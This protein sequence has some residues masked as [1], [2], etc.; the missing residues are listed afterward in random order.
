M[1]DRG[2]FYSKLVIPAQAGIQKHFLSGSP[3]ARGQWLAAR[4][5]GNDGK[6]SPT[7]QLNKRAEN[8]QDLC[9]NGYFAI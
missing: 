1:R 2:V 9:E 3:L 6:N 5:R 7:G 8:K 4:L